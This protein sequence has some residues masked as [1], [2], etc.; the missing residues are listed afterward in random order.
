MALDLEETKKGSDGFF[1]RSDVRET[2]GISGAPTIGD[3]TS[4]QHTHSDAASG[5]LTTHGSGDG[6][7]HADVLTNT[8]DIATINS[9]IV[10]SN[11]AGAGID[12]SAATGAVTISCEDSTTG[13][14]G[15]II[16][17]GGN[18]IDVSYASGNA[19]LTTVNGEINH[20]ALNNFTQTEHFTE[21]SIDHTN[22]TAGDGSDHS[23]LANKTSHWS[24]PGICFHT[25]NQDTDQ[26][27][28]TTGDFER[29]NGGVKHTMVDN[30]SYLCPVNLPQGAVV[31]SAKVSG[32][33]SVET[34]FLVETTLNSFVGDTNMATATLNTADTS[35]TNPTIDNSSHAYYFVVQGVDTGETIIDAQISYTTD[36]D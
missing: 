31:T 26:N 23:L 29:N 7:D 11:V 36:Y 18:G 4:A 2:A 9:S 20:D 15:I 27:L 25:F 35:I 14:K 5:G 19:T 21:T 33:S 16:V 8:N 24:Y 3:Y 6:S 1:L 12:V 22:I 30:G 34:W 28:G 10:T 13:N 32:N 17:T